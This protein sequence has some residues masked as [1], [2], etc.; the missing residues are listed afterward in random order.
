MPFLE[1]LLGTRP[2]RSSGRPSADVSYGSH[3]DPKVGFHMNKDSF[4][5]REGSLGTLIMAEGT[6]G[7]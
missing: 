5:L 1:I 4:S 7:G 2:L 3:S 6:H